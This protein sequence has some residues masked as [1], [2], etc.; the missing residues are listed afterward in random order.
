MSAHICEEVWR[1]QD[2]LQ[3]VSSLHLPCRSQD[4]TQ[5]VRTG[6]KCLH[7]LSPLA[8]SQ[9]TPFS[10]QTHVSVCHFPSYCLVSMYAP[11]VVLTTEDRLLN[12]LGLCEYKCVASPLSFRFKG[13]WTSSFIARSCSLTDGII[14]VLTDPR[15]CF[16]SLGESVVMTSL[17]R[18]FL[19]VMKFHL[20]SFETCF[21][22]K[23]WDVM[24]F[25]CPWLLQWS[26]SWRSLVLSGHSHPSSRGGVILFLF[27]YLFLG[28]LTGLWLTSVEP[29]SSS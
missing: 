4:W 14:L 29:P 6:C 20:F 19:I 18:S 7:L 26:S 13:V 22:F 23:I 1:P 28:L 17:F 12:R 3:G 24:L 16:D 8:C 21:L 25:V 11:S 27:L 9:L 2:N 15:A 5:V 10:D